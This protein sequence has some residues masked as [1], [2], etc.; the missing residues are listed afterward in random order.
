M[1]VND[2]TKVLKKY[3]CET[4]FYSIARAPIYKKHKRFLHP[5]RRRSFTQMA[6]TFYASKLYLATENPQRNV[7]IFIN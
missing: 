3:K 5:T 6:V 4:N 1:Q 7:P 2:Y